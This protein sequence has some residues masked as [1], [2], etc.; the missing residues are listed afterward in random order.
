MTI[1][2]TLAAL[3]G[4]WRGTN[5][6]WL[7]PTKPARESESLAIIAEAAHGQFIT[8]QYTWA[9]GD[10]PQEG[11]IVLGKETAGNVAQA[12]WIDSWHM[13]DKLMVCTGISEPNGTVWVKGEYEAPP[14]PNWG[15]QIAIV[16]EVD[17]TF[18]LVMHNITP[19][20]QE[21][22]AVEVIYVRQS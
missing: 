16:P 8:I 11:L 21:M 7:D 5:R 10:N 9:D 13:S 3:L 14:G 6:L 18:R 17:G 20:G 1:P 2:T 12:A 4:T 22:L 19:Q 15:W